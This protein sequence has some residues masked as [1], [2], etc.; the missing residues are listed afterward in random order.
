MM[1]RND[2]F[3]TRKFAI[4]GQFYLNFSEVKSLC[5][6]FWL[7]LKSVF[8]LSHFTSKTFVEKYICS[9]FQISNS[10]R[11]VFLTGWSYG[12]HFF[13][14]L[15]HLK[16]LSK[17]C[18]GCPKRWAVGKFLKTGYTH[19]ND[20]WFQA[21]QTAIPVVYL[22]I[23]IVSQLTL[24]KKCYLSKGKWEGTCLLNQT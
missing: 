16:I 18:R 5:L 8:E 2:K 3:I 22:S 12:H 19:Y 4:N 13:H 1:K 7:M 14:V 17:K 10:K 9:K 15:I 20:G 11:P 23:T 21:F 6:Y 24:E